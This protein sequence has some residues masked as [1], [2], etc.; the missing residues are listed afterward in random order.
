M[1]LY[2]EHEYCSDHQILDWQLV[3][4]LKKIYVFQCDHLLLFFSSF[5]L[6]FPKLLRE[7]EIVAEEGQMEV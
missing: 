5:S 3:M 4:P 1:V 7:I 2:E 6:Y